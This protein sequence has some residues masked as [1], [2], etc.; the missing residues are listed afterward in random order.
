VALGGLGAIAMKTKGP[1]EVGYM[2][3]EFLSS[4]REPY[5]LRARRQLDLP[6]GEVQGP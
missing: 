5:E 6:F 2:S 1:A 4:R 3:V